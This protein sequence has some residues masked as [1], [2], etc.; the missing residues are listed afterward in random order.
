M[1]QS[2]WKA[3]RFPAFYGTRRPITA[4]KC[5]RH[6]TLFWTSWIQSM[7]TYPT[8]WRSV[9][10]LS[11][12]LS[13]G[14]PSGLFPSGFPTKILYKPLLSLIRATCPTCL[15]LIDFITHIKLGEE[16]RSLSPSLCAVYN[17]QL[18]VLFSRNG[19]LRWKTMSIKSE[20]INDV[21]KLVD[22]ESDLVE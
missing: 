2:P 17:T 9:L 1:E 13:L 22:A 7:P 8:S 16:Y 15:I 11:S 18:I 4:F 3:N 20:W 14:L 6:L 12:H 19:R 10:I 5:A 21:G